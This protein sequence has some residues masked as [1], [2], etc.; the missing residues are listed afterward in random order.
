MS[1]FPVIVILL[2]GIAAVSCHRPIAASQAPFTIIGVV[3]SV[4]TRGM[5]LRHKSG[6]PVSIAFTP[7]TA[8]TRRGA[9][10][11]VGDVKVHM[12]IA[13]AYHFVD[14]TP[15]ADEIRLFRPAVD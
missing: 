12:R 8:F 13:V 14:G 11:E 9:P 3:E 15:T 10:A 5:R 7:Q 2:A 4:D 6:Q 1:R